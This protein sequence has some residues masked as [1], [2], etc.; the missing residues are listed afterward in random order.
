MLLILF[1]SIV[2]SKTVCAK[3]VPPPEVQSVIFQGLK[4]VAPN[5]P[6]RIGWVE[7]WDVE[8]NKKIWEKRVYKI[9]I[10][11]RMEADVQ[12]IFISA[13][14]LEKG[15]LVVLDEKGK[16][17]EIED[18][19]HK[20]FEAGPVAENPFI[21]CRTAEDCVLHFSLCDCR[22]HCYNNKTTVRDCSRE[23]DVLPNA[24]LCYCYHRECMASSELYSKSCDE[25]DAMRHEEFSKIDLSCDRDE[26]CIHTGGLFYSRCMNKNASEGFYRIIVITENA[27]N[28]RPAPGPSSMV[29]SGCRCVH[30]KCESTYR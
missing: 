7:A 9:T 20:H 23:C 26:D 19:P 21:I 30:Q 5:M 8:T 2:P 16:R 6:E 29:F 13:L 22:F 14:K 1:I 3:R 15:I 24:P 12:W 28:C 18:I 17:Y 25:L 11:P 10:D 27:K 4:F